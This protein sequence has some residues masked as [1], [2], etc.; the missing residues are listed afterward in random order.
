MSWGILAGLLFSAVPAFLVLA[1][2]FSPKR[3][4]IYLV[5]AYLFLLMAAFLGS[6]IKIIA[7][8]VAAFVVVAAVAVWFGWGIYTAGADTRQAITVGER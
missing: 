1:I 4:S 6:W 2:V 5:G 3:W 8:P 7:G